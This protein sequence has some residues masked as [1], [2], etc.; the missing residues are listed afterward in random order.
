MKRSIIVTVLLSVSSL[1]SAGVVG[2]C[3]DNL[4]KSEF[5]WQGL[6][7]VDG[8]QTYKAAQRPNLYREVNPLLGSHPST[9]EVIAYTA[10]M[11]V[12]HAGLACWIREKYGEPSSQFFQYTTIAIKGAGVALNFKVFLN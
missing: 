11:S 12:I 3:I 8:I 7:L 6:H 2:Q 9:G 10:G 4:P 5:V 1:T